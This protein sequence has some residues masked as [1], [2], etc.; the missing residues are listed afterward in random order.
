[1]PNNPFVALV[2][3]I[4]AA[5]TTLQTGTPTVLT[6]AQVATAAAPISG[7]KCE[8]TY[9]Y[10][11]S[12]S[13]QTD[14]QQCEND[15]SSCVTQK[16]TIKVLGL[17]KQCPTD[18]DCEYSCTERVTSKDGLRSCCLGGPG[19]PD[20]HATSCRKYVDNICNPGKPDAF[21]TFE[22]I[23]YDEGQKIPTA[24]TESITNAARDTSMDSSMVR[25][26]L[27]TYPKGTTFAADGEASKPALP[28]PMYPTIEVAPAFPNNRSYSPSPPSQVPDYV[29]QL[30]PEYQPTQPYRL[31]QPTNGYIDALAFNNSMYLSSQSAI[32]PGGPDYTLGAGNTFE[33][34]VTSLSSGSFDGSFP[35]ASNPSVVTLASQESQPG[36]SLNSIPNITGQQSGTQGVTTF[37]ERFNAAYASNQERSWGSRL[38]SAWQNFTGTVGKW[39][40]GK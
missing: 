22:G 6:S 15:W 25:M 13:R 23:L 3:I 11:M 4:V 27:L 10:C 36:N 7:G 37:D 24:N 39:F 32:P 29:Q 8:E 19:G 17:V 33:T 2:G 38:Q 34:G 28:D 14:K 26:P 5:L 31:P 16:C 9:R 12:D 20:G 30:P 21:T 1:M 40:G 35:V 18:Q